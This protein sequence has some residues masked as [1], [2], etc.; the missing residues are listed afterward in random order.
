MGLFPVSKKNKCC[1]TRYR[2]GQHKLGWFVQRGVRRRISVKKETW[3]VPVTTTKEWVWLLKESSCRSFPRFFCKWY[4]TSTAH[5][6]KGR[7]VDTIARIIISDRKDITAFFY[8]FF[9]NFCSNFFIFSP[10]V[11]QHIS[12]AAH[13]LFVGDHNLTLITI[14]HCSETQGH[15]IIIGLGYTRKVQTT[16]HPKPNT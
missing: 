14:W 7:L 16:R 13:S 10:K 6:F 15:N 11:L 9:R 12:N 5:S 4:R 2:V 8:I 1:G 3:S